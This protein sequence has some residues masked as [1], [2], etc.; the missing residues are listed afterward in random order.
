MILFIENLAGLEV[1]THS[2]ELRDRWQ[3]LFISRRIQDYLPASAPQRGIAVVLPAPLLRL[4][5]PALSV[6]QMP[7]TQQDPLGWA[8]RLGWYRG[9]VS[10][11]LLTE[12]LVEKLKVPVRRFYSLLSALRPSNVVPGSAIVGSNWLEFGCMSEVAYRRHLEFLRERYPAAGYYL[13]PRETSGIP[14]RIF[15]RGMVRRPRSTLEAHFRMDGTPE[16]LIGI[17]SSTLLT[18]PLAHPARIR[19]DLIEVP[20]AS[21]DGVRGGF[22]EILRRPIDGRSNIGVSDLQGFLR[23]KLVAGG[24]SVRTVRQPS[25]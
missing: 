5:K 24:V 2:T 20:D 13:H 3:I 23:G 7:V 22:V 17:C 12:Y 16:L 6:L 19:V 10:D 21:F 8:F 15:G 14:E 4:L 9:V 11:G 18:A 1:A 25:P